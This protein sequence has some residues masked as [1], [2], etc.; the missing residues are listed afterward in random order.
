MGTVHSVKGETHIAT[1]YLETFHRDYEGNRI[2]GYICGN[3]SIPGKELIK[4]NL[5]I[6]HVGMSRPT[7]LLCIAMHKDRIGCLTCQ[8][9]NSCHWEIIDDL[10]VNI[11]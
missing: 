6:A 8:N 2:K 1:L 10:V 3:H 7:H 4:Y 11:K 9:K 5:K